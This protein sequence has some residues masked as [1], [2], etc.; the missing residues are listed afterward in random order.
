MV[1][2]HAIGLLASSLAVL[3]PAQQNGLD[4]QPLLA[5]VGSEIGWQ[6][7]WE[8]AAEVARGSNSPLLLVL[9]EYRAFDIP[10]HK[11]LRGLCDIDVARLIAA[12]FVPLRHAARTPA[13]LR[14]TNGEPYHMGPNTLGA[15]LLVVKPDGEVVAETH[16]TSPFAVYDFL[17][18]SLRRVPDLAG[19]D[20]PSGISAAT[21]AARLLLRGEHERAAQAL[22]EPK[23]A[24]D[25]LA[26]AGLRRRQR[27]GA[28]ALE[29]LA[30]AR[31]LIG[32]SSVAQIDLAELVVHLR[33]G[34]SR[35]AEL[36][37]RA[38]AAH[39]EPIVTAA[40]VRYW[41]AMS[42]IQAG[43]RQRG[44]V[45][46]TELASAHAEDR[47]AW[48]GAQVLD[49]LRE[50]AN[51]RIS[52]AWPP[53]AVVASVR[54][55][56]AAAGDSRAVVELEAAEFL[57][58][59]QRED[60]SWISPVELV[61]RSISH[62][63]TLAK[64]ALAGQALLERGDVDGNVGAAER[65]MQFLL[66]RM[67]AA[68]NA[69]PAKRSFMDYTVWSESMMLSFFA[70]CSDARIGDPAKLREAMTA[71]AASLVKKQRPSGGFSYY[72][73]ND[74]GPQA[75]PAPV[76]P[77]SMS[78]TTAAAVIGMLRARTA[79]ATVDAYALERAIDCVERA[80]G[81]NGAF[82]YM[83]GSEAGGA[84]AR[85]G[86]A[87][88]GPACELALLR[89]GRADLDDIRR[90]LAIFR[91]HRGDYAREQGKALMHCGA[92]GQGCHYLFFDY[93]MAAAA[94]HELP[95]EER[96]RHAEWLLAD[97]ILPARSIEGGFRGTPIN[98][99]AF[100]TAMALM[101]MRDLGE[102]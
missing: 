16:V 47:W 57:R 97:L 86:A 6:P 78:F 100:G 73:T 28:E 3:C 19:V 15:A 54:T 23:S 58:R 49:A 64:T 17:R 90:A 18:A 45:M 71:L 56:A 14:R 88:R 61:T 89:A 94:A 7:N 33:L 44:A 99:W 22:G 70:D 83:V 13:P 25:H 40:V 30:V 93:A 60:G 69:E 39:G 98:G 67:A 74:L 96:A 75:K 5:K 80:R 34:D 51:A 63:F 37:S 36:A 81:D 101:A 52:V 12:R 76:P 79:G 41:R 26:T 92:Q 50:D 2:R 1:R 11:L 102:E 82:R 66:R 9:H 87:G 77:Q 10:S 46:L 65:A 85:P 32:D 42:A 84:E 43:E 24:A 72:I 91:E 27:R 48:Q 59:E 21:E 29:H 31:R 55:P 8:R 95:A 35:A 4:L 53:D 20:A 62:P 38:L 68:E